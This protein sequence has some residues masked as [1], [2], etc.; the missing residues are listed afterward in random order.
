MVSLNDIRAVAFNL[1]V[2][3][4]LALSTT[5]WAHVPYTSSCWLMT[6]A[7][8][9]TPHWFYAF[10]WT[11]PKTFMTICQKLRPG[12]IMLLCNLY[13]CQLHVLQNTTQGQITLTVLLVGLVCLRWAFFCCESFCLLPQKTAL[14]TGCAGCI[15]FVVVL[16]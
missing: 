8:V 10:V 6:A 3:S 9:S 5:Y 1:S 2:L 13:C 12:T 15:G 16:L 14:V 4:L 11:Q 7:A